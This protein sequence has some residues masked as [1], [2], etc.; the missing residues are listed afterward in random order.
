MLVAPI[1]G[2][3]FALNAG[4]IAW[5]G[6][7]GPDELEWLSWPH[8]GLLLLLM[9]QRSVVSLPV[10]LLNGN[11]LFDSRPKLREI[12]WNSLRLYPRYLWSQGV[13]W[14]LQC[15]VL[16]WTFVLP[17]RA[18]ISHFFRGEVIVLE[19]LGGADM[20]RRLGAMAAGQG[21][22]TVAFVI[23]DAV[24]FA[25][26]LLAVAYAFNV[27]LGMASLDGR[28]WW[29]DADIT[30]FS[31]VMHL[32]VLLY[33]PLHTTA[34]FLYYIDSRSQREGWDIELTMIKGVRE[35][36]EAA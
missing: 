29:L 6:R 16:V 17:W 12:L 33:Y 1:V 13:L 22:R 19:R 24:F 34:K 3:C 11:L 2:L 4:L 15:V 35:T 31:P 27:T 20:R 18:L 7:Y 14:L 32:F 23:L 21:E 25:L 28:F 10:L 5:L 30:L 8:L 9:F 36:E 26:Y